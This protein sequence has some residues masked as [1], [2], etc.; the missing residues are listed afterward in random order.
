MS[1]TFHWQQKC[2]SPANVISPFI[3][4]SHSTLLKTSVKSEVF[5]LK[6]SGHWGWTTGSIYEEALFSSYG[7]S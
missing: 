1:I 7:D 6:R 4:L 5:E 2:F 3:V